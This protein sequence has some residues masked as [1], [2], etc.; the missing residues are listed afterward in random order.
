MLLNK[1]NLEIVKIDGKDEARY[2]LYGRFIV[3]TALH[4]RILRAMLFL[5]YNELELLP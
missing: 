2:T 5:C 4:S 1:R 3:V